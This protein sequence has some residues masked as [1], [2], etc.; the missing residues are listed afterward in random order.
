MATTGSISTFLSSFKKD[1]AKPNHFDV[2][3]ATPI[4]LQQYSDFAKTLSFRC[5]STELPG[6]SL[7]T[8][9]MKIY[10]I[11][12]KFPYMSNFNDI[13][14]SFIVSDDMREKRFFETWL[15]YIHPNSTY[16]FKYKNEYSVEL[17][18]TQY[19]IKKRPSYRVKL[20]ECYPIAVNQLDLNWGSDGYHRL[21]VT[22]VYTS[23]VE[24]LETATLDPTVVEEEIALLPK[25]VTINS[26]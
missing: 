13:T 20:F 2:T 14:L 15:N 3:I 21:G 11:E 9:S 26:I 24:S 19:D 23:W 16:N 17:K 18:I 6:R 12:E 10:G 8:T 1:L 25:N 5:E 22:F 7:M 4:G